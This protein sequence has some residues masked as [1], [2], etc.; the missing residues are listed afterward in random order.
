MRSM[1]VVT[2]ALTLVIAAAACEKKNKDPG[3]GENAKLVFVNFQPTIMKIMSA[4][5]AAKGTA[6]QGANIPEIGLVGLVQ[7]TGTVGGT[8]AQSGGQNENLNLW[9]SLRNE[10]SDTGDIF[11]ETD[12]TNDTTKLQFG[13]NI[14]NQPQDNTMNGTLDGPLT[15]TG[16][17]EGTATL[18]LGFVSD[19]DDDNVN[20][21]LICTHVT[22]TVATAT[23]TTAL[24]FVIS[25]LSSALDPV[26][27]A[28]CEGL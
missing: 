23:N 24:N 20:S 28:K 11:F 9:V 8:V 16:D 6:S 15:L 18:A 14:Q 22:G 25:H 5:I 12:D 3:T 1:L 13:L 10:Y 27:Q 7:G 19:L 2:S 17:V 21:F 4:G 26:Q